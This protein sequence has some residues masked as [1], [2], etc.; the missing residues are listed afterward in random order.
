MK[1]CEQKSI[2]RT[3][4]KNKEIKK[5]KPTKKNLVDRKI[6]RSKK[7]ATIISYLISIDMINF[8]GTKISSHLTSQSIITTELLL[9]FFMV[10]LGHLHINVTN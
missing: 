1:Q 4:K 2:G 10:A 6:Q 3:K 9:L 8:L 7:D 5:I